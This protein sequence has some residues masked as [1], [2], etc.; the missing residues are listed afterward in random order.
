MRSSPFLA[1]LLA[2]CSGAPAIVDGG[3][4]PTD[5]GDRD[6][7]SVDAG[8]V[9]AGPGA[10]DAGPAPD[11]GGGSDAGVD[12]GAPPPG[13]TPACGPDERCD[14]GTCVPNDPV[15]VWERAGRTATDS[16]TGVAPDGT[17]GVAFFSESMTF[18]SEAFDVLYATRDGAGWT[19]EPV[20][21]DVA[22]L[23]LELEL[24]F[25][26]DGEPMIAWVG[27][28]FYDTRAHYDVS[29]ARRGPG[30]WSATSFHA[31]ESGAEIV[32]IGLAFDPTSD[33]LHLVRPRA[34]VITGRPA[35]AVHVYEAAGGVMEREGMV[36][37]ADGDP[38][39]I[40]YLD[41][42]VTS[43]GDVVFASTTDE[44]RR[45]DNHI[46]LSTLDGTRWPTEIAASWPWS[47]LGGIRVGYLD[48]HD[49]P[50]GLVILTLEDV[51]PG[52][53]TFYRFTF[54]DGAGF[55]THTGP[56]TVGPSSRRVC[57]DASAAGDGVFAR[58]DSAGLHVRSID[59]AGAWAHSVVTMESMDGFCSVAH[60][61]AT[62]HLAF[63]DSS[64]GRLL[65]L[66][67]P[68]P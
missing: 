25:G 38:I 1:L 43:A 27:E 48:V 61:G 62:A 9:D 5:A 41:A 30:G 39:G 40:F 20:A 60:A 7:G 37:D 24:A 50:R 45:T 65:Y 59:R 36:V 53:D 67:A 29:V 64:T 12:A 6:A 17:V 51:R 15:V 52:E 57:S 16:A 4:A 19:V 44:S 47:G 42:A 68:L 3:P 28:D 22:G 54:E 63:T 32:P 31:F 26:A 23:G 66:E 13:C 18:P 46:A 14:A 34:N 58:L 21:D 49:T 11:A 33:A 35:Y 8:A 55:T 56:P 10:L 2:A